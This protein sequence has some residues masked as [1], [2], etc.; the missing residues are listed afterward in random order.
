MYIEWTNYINV[1]FDSY[2]RL[3]SFANDSILTFVN[4]TKVALISINKVKL[5]IIILLTIY[6]QY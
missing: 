5:G 4:N 2:T 3:L 1:C 6:K